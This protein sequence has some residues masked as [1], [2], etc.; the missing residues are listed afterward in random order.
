MS[1]VSE[2]APIRVLIVDDH[3]M[4]REGLKIL[5]STTNDL[6]VVGEAEGGTEA[7]EACR[8]ARPDVVLMDVVMPGMDGA[9]ATA[10]LLEACPEVRV[11]ALTSFVEQELVERTLDAGAI[12]Y[13]LKDAQPEKLAQAIREASHGR[14][15]IDSG[16]ME[17]VRKPKLPHASGWHLT[18]RELEV[19][20]LL[21]DG[22]SNKEIASRL[23]LSC[24]TVR[25]HVSNILTKL[26]A[27]NRTA[28][29]MMAMK[30]R[31]D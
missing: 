16:A 26:G 23:T 25:L 6:L 9:T 27:T 3:L 10:H 31:Q 1:V 29:A 18:P 28:A 21:S 14:G 13:L 2:P 8:E 20:A 11:I 4:V 24:G 19:L 12:S 30:R 17:A 5:L 15:T 7:L 22:L